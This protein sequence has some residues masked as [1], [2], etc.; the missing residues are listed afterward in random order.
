MLSRSHQEPMGTNN[1]L[2]PDLGRHDKIALFL[3][4]VEANAVVWSQFLLARTRGESLFGKAL[5]DFL[6]VFWRTR[7]NRDPCAGNSRRQGRHN[8]EF[9][10]GSERLA[11]QGKGVGDEKL[12]EALGGFLGKQ[13]GLLIGQPDLE[14]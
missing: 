10:D 12:D 5:D 7:G 13:D 4:G 1:R 6:E 2:Q 3:Q 11:I 9:P 14:I 8:V